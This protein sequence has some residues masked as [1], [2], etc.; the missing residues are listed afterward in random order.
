M[1]LPGCISGRRQCHRLGD[2]GR[3]GEFPTCRWVVAGGLS[4]FNCRLRF[5]GRYAPPG[6]PAYRPSQGI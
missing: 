1:A 3:R 4:T 5:G 6:A 2:A